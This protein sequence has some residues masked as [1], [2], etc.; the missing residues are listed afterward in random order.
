MALV[1]FAPNFYSANAHGQAFLSKS[2]TLTSFRGPPITACIF[3]VS[4]AS[5]VLA[6]LVGFAA[7]FDAPLVLF[8]ATSSQGLSVLRLACDSVG[9]FYDS[10]KLQKPVL[11]EGTTRT[12]VIFG[13]PFIAAGTSQ[14]SIDAAAVWAW[15]CATT[16]QRTSQNHPYQLGMH[17]VSDF[18]M[19]GAMSPPVY[20][21]TPNY[22]NDVDQLTKR[23]Q[24]KT[25]TATSQYQ[26][27]LDAAV[28]RPGLAAKINACL[29]PYIVLAAP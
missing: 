27:L 26:T 9:R 29:V 8:S 12:P 21:L 10:A 18:S 28:S 16:L 13:G 20:K 15:S 25:V 11:V 14:P 17:G 24:G 7:T 5:A 1:Q 3:G 22:L 4:P 23:W 19:A 2:L 6:S